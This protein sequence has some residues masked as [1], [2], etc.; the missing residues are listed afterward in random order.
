[1]NLPPELDDLKEEIKDHAIDCGLD[2]F[3]VVF[4]V[5]THDQINQIAAL[6]GF[7]NR[8]PHWKFGMEYERL[9]KSYTYGLSKIY[10]MVINNDPCYAYLMNSNPLCDQK[11]VMAHVYA[12]SDFFKNNCFFA[13][14]SRKAID[15]LANHGARIRSYGERYGHDTV[16]EFLDNCLSIENLID[17][18]STGIRRVE[19]VKKI[20][21]LD[22]IAE[23][24]TLEVLRIRSK[25]YMDRFVN[26]KEFLDQKK[27]ELEEERNKKTRIPE[28][29]TRDI[30]KFLIDY[31]PLQKW[32]RDILGIVRDEAYYFAP[33]GMTKIMNEGWATYW[34]S[35]MMTEK[36]ANDRDI[37]DY[38]DHHSGTVAMGPNSIN[39]YK[40]GVELYRDI[41]DRWNKGRHGIEW[42]RCEDFDQRQNWDTRANAGRDKI[43]EVRRN[44]ND[45][46]FIDSFFTK[47]FCEEHK[48]FAYKFNRKSGVYEISSR[49]FADVKKQFLGSLTNAGQPFIY[50]TDANYGNRGELHLRHRFE[51]VELK[52][53]HARDT[54][55]NIQK[56]WKRP[57][58]I[59]SVFN[60]KGRLL[61]YDGKD[62]RDHDVVVEVPDELEID[63]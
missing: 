5:L 43:F 63:D 25:E 14:T 20:S 41:E 62:H 37:I 58:H 45:V 61:S 52:L 38:A 2:F 46:T 6:G 22:E 13:H 59:E 57:V 54:I 31:A 18:H 55:E 10:E 48:L 15:D 11:L 50:V 60:G 9:S 35:K 40:I 8:Y 53:D 47:E 7:P 19:E 26:P 32:Q 49:E 39:P 3:D 24:E 30:L 33:Q 29:P 34:H 42:D 44:H 17:I 1:M 36:L 27:K 21:E 4:E 28:E 51:G 56:I 23:E 16:E 12:H